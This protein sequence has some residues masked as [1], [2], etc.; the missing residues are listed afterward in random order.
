MTI[1]TLTPTDVKKYRLL[2]LAALHEQPPAFGTPA[3]KEEKLAL[4]AMVLRLQESEDTYILGAFSDDSLVGTIRFSRFEEANE[5]HRGFIAG[6][7][8]RPDFRRHGLARALATEVLVRARQDAG[9][10]RIH[11]TVITAQDA[12]IQLYKSLGFCI[13]GTEHEAFS[14]QGQ[15][16]DEHLMDL[17]LQAKTN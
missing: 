1:R 8:V 12:A 14:N 5:K 13:Y 9:L 10:R 17:L 16:Y 15:F 6:L 11:L 4:E 2:R 3:E 7:Y